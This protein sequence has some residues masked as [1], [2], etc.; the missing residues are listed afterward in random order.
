[1][2]LF[3]QAFAPNL[4]YVLSIGTE[5]D[6]TVNVWNWKTGI[7]VASNKVA[8]KVMTSGL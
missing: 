8:Q 7:K 4:K 3:F 1:M 5:H 6:M 2:V